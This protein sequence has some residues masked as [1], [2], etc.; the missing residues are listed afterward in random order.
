MCSYSAIRMRRVTE[1][2]WVSYA[3]VQVN[4]QRGGRG[5]VPLI[6]ALAATNYQE[7]PAVRSATKN[8]G[9]W[10]IAG[11]LIVAAI[12]IVISSIRNLSTL[13]N[14]LLQVLSLGLGLAGSFVIGREDAKE[15]AKDIIKPHAKSA[16]RRVLSLYNSL[17]RLASAIEHQKQS[18]SENEAG[19]HS[20][21]KLQ[22]IVIEQI[23][24]ADDA[25]EDWKD[26]LPE[27]L[28]KLKVSPKRE[29]ILESNSNE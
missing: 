26:I 22:G 9:G 10:L 16:F 14:T 13:E 3:V 11:S 12:F 7:F 24:T 4:S 19:I 5:P 21:E 8:Q 2:C 1:C 6:S 17:S 15:N 29:L 27:E 23:S 20:L 25:L 18:L 28:S